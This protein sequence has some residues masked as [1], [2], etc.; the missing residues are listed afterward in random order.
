MYT[1][2]MSNSCNYQQRSAV[3]VEIVFLYFAICN[4]VTLQLVIFL[5]HLPWNK[6]LNL[7]WSSVWV[8]QSD[9]SGWLTLSFE[10]HCFTRKGKT[11][12]HTKINVIFLK[13]LRLCPGINVLWE[14]CQTSPM[15]L[16]F[17]IKF[18]PTVQ[19]WVAQPTT[20]LV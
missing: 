10:L 6:W 17:F 15:Y 8:C 1:S 14:Q 9:S 4:S 5:I 2:N 13:G 12:C 18:E 20:Y 7:P 19:Y 11:F 3:V 16:S